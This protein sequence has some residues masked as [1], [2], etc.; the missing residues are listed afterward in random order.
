M[1]SLVKKWIDSVPIPDGLFLVWFLMG[2]PGIILLGL[3]NEF[4]E[5]PAVGEDSVDTSAIVWKFWWMRVCGFIFGSLAIVLWLVDVYRSKA[6]GARELYAGLMMYSLFSIGVG[7]SNPW[8]IES[9]NEL[10]VAYVERS[11]LDDLQMELLT[12][13]PEDMEYRQWL[14]G[15]RHWRPPRPR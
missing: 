5:I 6:G 8:L 11:R 4:S 7:V 3:S 13:D 1:K 14:E 9:Q 10:L 15:S 12:Y 2:I